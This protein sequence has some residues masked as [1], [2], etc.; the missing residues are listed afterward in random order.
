MEIKNMP[1]NFF[2]NSDQLVD[3][4]K[5]PKDIYN[6]EEELIDLEPVNKEKDLEE[7]DLY[8]IDVIVKQTD[9]NQIGN[10][11]EIQFGTLKNCKTPT[12]QCC[13]RSAGFTLCAPHC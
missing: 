7:E 12:S 10:P 3:K 4:K 13:Y 5:E 2:P 11:P 6:H 1:F 8:D 9:A